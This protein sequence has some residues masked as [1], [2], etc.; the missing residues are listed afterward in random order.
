MTIYQCDM[1]HKNFKSKVELL[2]LT[3]EPE[4]YNDAPNVSCYR[5]CGSRV[6]SEL[7]ENC[8]I[9]VTNTIVDM[10]ANGGVTIE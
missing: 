3:I 7:C 2:R 8:I 4:K 6:V 10:I 5:P 1:C 9:T